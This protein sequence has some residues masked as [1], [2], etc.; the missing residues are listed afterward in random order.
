MKMIAKIMKQKNKE[1][2]KMITRY[3]IKKKMMKR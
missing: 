2:E 1:D 3:L